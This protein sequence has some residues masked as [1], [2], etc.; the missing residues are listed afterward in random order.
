VALKLKRVGIT[1]VHPLHGG[2]TLWMDRQ[3]P[4]TELKPTT[5]LEAELSTDL[6]GKDSQSRGN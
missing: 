4:T 3:F 2:L 1:R 5:S 6:R